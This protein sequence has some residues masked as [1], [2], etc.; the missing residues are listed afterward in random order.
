MCKMFVE[1]FSLSFSV[2]AAILFSRDLVVNGLV[3]DGQDT[4]KILVKHRSFFG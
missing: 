2:W 4:G 3:K 1:L